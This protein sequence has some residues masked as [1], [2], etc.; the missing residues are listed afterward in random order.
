ML[1]VTLSALTAH[2]L[3]LPNKLSL[4]GPLWLAVQQHL[5]RGWGPYIGPVDWPEYRLRWEA[6]HGISFLLVVSA[7]VIQLWSLFQNA[8]NRTA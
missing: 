1:A 3:E 2:V 4:D 8:R 5:Y 6:G 7:F